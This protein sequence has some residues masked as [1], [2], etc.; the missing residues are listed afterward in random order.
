MKRLLLLLLLLACSHGF[1]TDAHK[2]FAP[3]KYDGFSQYVSTL[4]NHGAGGP[5]NLNPGWTY[6]QS[7]STATNCASTSCNITQFTPTVAGSV[8]IVVTANG[9]NISPTS[10]TGG[11][12]TWTKCTVCHGFTSFFGS[13][14]IFYNLSGTT[15]TTT[16][17]VNYAVAPSTTSFTE[18]MEILP[19]AGYTASFD[20]GG[21]TGSAV[22]TSGCV[23]PALTLAGT[24]AIIMGT[25]YIPNWNTWN[26]ITG[27]SGYPWFASWFGD[28][29]CLNCTVGTAPN[30]NVTSSPEAGYIGIAI[31]FKSS[32]ASFTTPAALMNFANIT[33]PNGASEYNCSPTCSITVPSTTAG[34]LLFIEAST[35][36]SNDYISSVSGGGTWVVP[37]A[38]QKQVTSPSTLNVSCA[39]V[40]SASGGTTSIAVTMAGSSSATGIG[41]YE[42]HRTSGSWALDTDGSTANTASFTPPLQPLTL[43]GTNDVV[44]QVMGDIGGIETCQ[45]YPW[46]TFNQPVTTDTSVYA[47]LNAPSIPASAVCYNPQN[48]ITVVQGV[49]FK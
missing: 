34:N 27:G 1:A 32:A 23:G 18:F 25:D 21:Y 13:S 19:P 28:G 6:V 31:A 16:V 12:G 39:Y 44:F 24:D 47:I 20:T 22:C 8:W 14:D 2:T 37:V 38:C 5:L 46:Y 40:L 29:L 3:P 45:Y 17:T 49:A 41:I 7:G 48:S 43:T 26:F 33:S 35:Q 15:S 9:A 10:V 11:G 36:V 4:H 30:V 42:V